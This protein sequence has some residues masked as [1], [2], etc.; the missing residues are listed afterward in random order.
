MRREI[1]LYE[2]GP[3]INVYLNSSAR[4]YKDGMKLFNNAGDEVK[5]VGKVF[6]KEYN[7]KSSYAVQF[8]D[9]TKTIVCNSA[10]GTGMY[11]NPNKPSLYNVGYVGQGPWLTTIKGKHTKEYNLWCGVM[12]R[13]YCKKYKKEKPTYMSVTVDKRWHNFQN[14][15]EDIQYL[16]NYIDWKK[17]VVPRLWDIDKDIKVP[18]NKVYHKDGCTFVKHADN[19]SRNHKKQ[20][21]TGLTYIAENIDRGIKQEFTNQR[22]FAEEARIP[23]S[24]IYK[25]LSGEFSQY[26]GWV[27]KIKGEKID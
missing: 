2:G 4:K 9:G 22:Q 18:G 8:T 16:E 27:I 10:L 26:S 19:L 23:R 15:C 7:R 14:F 24:A 13:G 21:I 11:R 6:F 25:C 5:I 17:N 12:R 3:V 1:L 20:T